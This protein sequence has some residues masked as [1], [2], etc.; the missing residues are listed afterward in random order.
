[1]ECDGA[2]ARQRGGQQLCRQG[3]QHTPGVRPS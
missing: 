3:D 1:M 2:N